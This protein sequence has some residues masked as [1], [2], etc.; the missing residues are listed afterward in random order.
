M[1]GNEQELRLPSTRAALE[2]LC[3]PL[4]TPTFQLTAWQALYSQT[5]LHPQPEKSISKIIIKHLLQPE[6]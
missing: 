1:S 4:K 2:G 5:K 6:I 3:F